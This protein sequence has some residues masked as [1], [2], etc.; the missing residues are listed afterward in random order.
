MKYEEFIREAQLN[1]KK[2]RMAFAFENESNHKIEDKEAANFNAHLV[3][4]GWKTTAAISVPDFE[5]MQ[6]KLAVDGKYD[7]VL[8]G[9]GKPVAAI[10]FTKIKKL[11]FSEVPE[12][13]AKKDGESDSLEQWRRLI[14]TMLEEREQYFPEMDIVCL[15]FKKIYPEN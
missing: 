13:F 14:R 10:Q 7:I 6:P 3:L 1:P 8:D 9:E 4:K 12:E 15:E 2:F 11:K 5:A